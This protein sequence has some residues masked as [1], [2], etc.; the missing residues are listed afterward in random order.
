MDSRK[1]V[2]N[3]VQSS[4]RFLVLAEFVPLPGHNI[5]N[6]EKFLQEYGEKKGQIPAEFELAGIT[7]PQS[8]GGVASMSPA[9]IYSI[10]DKKGLWADLDVVPHVT[11]KDHNK[12]GILSYL[13]GLQKLGIESVLALT[14]DKPAD[15]KGV[16][17]LDSTDLI[18]LLKEMNC[19][20]LAKA[21]PGS[22]DKAHQFYVAAAVSQ[23]KY[24]EASQMQQY[25]KMGK[26]L[27]AGADCLITQLGWDWRKC[28]ELFRY[29]KEQ[30]LAVPV[31]GNVYVLTTMT[32]APRLMHTGKL[33]GCVVTKELFEKLGSETAEQHLERAA[34]QVA[35]FRE[36]G[37]VGI[38]LGGLLD[39]GMMIEILEKA[40]KIGKNWREYQNNLDF[41]VK[42]GF[43]LYKGGNQRRTLSK[44]SPGFHKRSFDLFHNMFLAP[45]KGLHGG[46]KKLFG[47]SKGLR[48]GRGLLY[49]MF[50]D[51]FE[52]PVKSMMFD[53]EEC[54]DCF[55]VENF[56]ICSMGKCEK[57]LTN[58]P[59]GDA[60]PDGTCGNNPDIKCVGE[61]IYEAAASEGEEGLKKLAETLNK[62]RDPQLAGTSS[63][64]NYLFGKDHMKKV[65]LIQIGESVHA[66]IPK[67]GAAM[68]E[69]H[70]MGS[71]AY[72][73]PSGALDYMISLITSQ[74]ALHADYIAIN[75]DAFG[76]DDPKLAEELMC[77]YV[78]LVKKHSQGVPPCVDSSND[79]V[80]Q[81]GLEEYY[82]DLPKNSPKPLIN[83]VKTYTIERILPLAKKY[84]F[85]V[86][87]L[88]VSD[89][90]AGSDGAYS[91]NELHE[92]AREI[93]EAAVGKYGFMPDELFFDSTV[94][95]LAIDMPMSPDTPGYTYRAFETIRKITTDPK[96]KGVHTSLG[97]SNSVKDLPGRKIGVCR[98]YVAKAMEYGLDAGIVNV[99]HEYGL[100]PVDPDLLELVDA[101]AKQDGSAERSMKAMELMGEFC[102]A[103][104]KVSR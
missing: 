50:F 66:S 39:F 47:A 22:F 74:A 102:R 79:K 81:A 13:T 5:V 101:F 93:F 82:R 42:D 14:G 7:I 44:P 99:A 4:D 41:G 20:S 36:M 8:P 88:L 96:M 28:E 27:M 84:P 62:K 6:F 52:K 29:L 51:G 87:G 48:E 10:L 2:K 23:Y 83:S 37:A 72:D 64:L 67:P 16:F 18:A 57:G 77:Q 1:R 9:D 91:M 97:I 55:L 26:K 53:C 33:P 73:K 61:L 35:M 12:D 89:K 75:V 90:E 24:T 38:D 56:G 80:L 71:G 94:F 78:R 43:Y 59:C 40:K 46:L 60:N 85:K 17:E 70:A 32:P 31:F 76:E 11:T 25:F 30:S 69:V 104:R 100:K 65:K 58:A 34:Q 63:I 19:D 86:I 45:G 68:K 54:G 15:S 21:K 98:A 95:P 3:L 103:N 92:M 49:K